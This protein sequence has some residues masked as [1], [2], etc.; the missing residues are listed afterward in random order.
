MFTTIVAYV[1]FGLTSVGI[2][3]IILEALIPKSKM[4]KTIQALEAYRNGY[5]MRYDYRKIT[6]LLSVWFIT[7]WYLFG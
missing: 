3:A 5:T 1:M 7:G 4:E 2:F 6:L